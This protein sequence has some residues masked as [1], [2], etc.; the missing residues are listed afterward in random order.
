MA[1]HTLQECC[2]PTCCPEHSAIAYLNLHEPL[3]LN[4]LVRRHT[5]GG[6]TDWNEVERKAEISAG[7][8]RKG[9]TPLPVFHLRTTQE[10]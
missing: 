5:Q 9:Y 10:R 4:R 6:V 2:D 8:L 7:F 3:L 1:T